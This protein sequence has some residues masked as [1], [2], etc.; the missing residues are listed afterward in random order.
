M[1]SVRIFVGTG[2]Q[3]ALMLLGVGEH[4]GLVHDGGSR[5]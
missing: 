4:G 2:G 5:S 1:G 3:A